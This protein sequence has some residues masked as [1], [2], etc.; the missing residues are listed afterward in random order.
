MQ[1]SRLDLYE[2]HTYYGWVK[3][4]CLFVYPE[5]NAN[6]VTGVGSWLGLYSHWDHHLASSSHPKKLDESQM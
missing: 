2:A 1:W 4:L 6:F 5:A 3:T